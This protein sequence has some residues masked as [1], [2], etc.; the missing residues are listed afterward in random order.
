MTLYTLTITD[1]VSCWIYIEAQSIHYEAIQLWMSRCEYVEA[2]D[3]GFGKGRISADDDQHGAWRN[4]TSAENK[5][6][7]NFWYSQLSPSYT[8]K[9]AQIYVT[10]IFKHSD[11]V[12]NF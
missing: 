1:D 6:L 7:R 2:D 5:K 9:L 8:K 3:L 11:L 10:L 4:F 12:G